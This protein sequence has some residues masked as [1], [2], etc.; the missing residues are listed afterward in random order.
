MPK[1]LI[2]EDDN[3]IR[4]LLY[5]YLTALGY[6]AVTAEN[7]PEAIAAARAQTEL[8]LIL[9]DLMLPFKSGDSVLKAIREFSAVPVIVVSA[10]DG[11]QTK[12]DLLRLGAD[13]YITKPF[14]LDEL[15]VRIETVLRRCGAGMERKGEERLTL[16]SLTLDRRS[17]NAF[18]GGRQLVLTVKEYAILE[19]LLLNPTKLFSKANL[20]ESVWNEPYLHDDNTLKVH[21]SNLRGK[22][23]EYAPDEE[24]I[25]TVWGMGYKLRL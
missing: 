14:D 10:K 17:G 13:D 4:R 21:M 2:A 23:K 6:R 20:F 15:S 12:I 19:L 1:I 18:I 22:L 9:L 24:F 25:E 3:E 16:R 8:S 11:V 5:D 7:G